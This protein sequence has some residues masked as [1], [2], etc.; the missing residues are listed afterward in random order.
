MVRMAKTNKHG[1]RTGTGQLWQGPGIGM[2]FLKIPKR[3]I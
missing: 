2:E 3:E 1:R